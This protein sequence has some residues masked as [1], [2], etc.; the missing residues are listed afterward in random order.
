MKH[1]EAL[2]KVFETHYKWHE[3]R[4]SILGNFI[5]SVIRSRSVNL[6]KVAENIE[7]QAKIESNYRRIQRLFQ[8][9]K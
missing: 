4:V 8:S 7:G 6:Q 1:I 5:S 2:K 9:K 3:D